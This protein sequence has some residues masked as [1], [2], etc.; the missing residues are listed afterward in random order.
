[1]TLWIISVVWLDSEADAN[2]TP[3]ESV[4]DEL[5][6]THSAGFLIKETETFILLALSFD[7]TTQ[8]INTFKKIPLAAIQKITKIKKVKI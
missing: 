7:E 1:M 2:W 8:S 6:I 3:L 4:T 5:D